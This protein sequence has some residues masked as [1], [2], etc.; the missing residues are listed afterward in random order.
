M[1]TTSQLIQTVRQFMDFAMHHSMRE[2]AHFV[3]ATGLSMPLFGILMQLH[4]RSNCGVSDLSERFDITNA[5][6]SQLVDKLVQSGL[7][8][9][10]EDP[11]DRRAR[12]LNI[13]EKGKHLIQQGIEERYR[14]VD[15]LAGKLT[16]E[17]REKVTEALDIMTTAARDLETQPAEQAS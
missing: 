16:A 6:A 3:K 8:Q 9:R 13:T 15:Q 2:R 11:N 1:T 14:W 5:A 12:L 4:Y 17:Q 10:E 7:I